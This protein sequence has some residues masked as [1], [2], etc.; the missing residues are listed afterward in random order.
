[1][2]VPPLAN[3]LKIEQSLEESIG[4][5]NQR[6]AD[7]KKRTFRVKAQLSMA[8]ALN[9]LSVTIIASDDIQIILDGL[10]NII[11]ETLQVDHC[12]LYEINLVMNKMEKVSE[13]QRAQT[14]E[15]QIF[16]HGH[17][18]DINPYARDFFDHNQ[19]RIESHSHKMDSDLN[20]S[21]MAEFIHN[22]CKI[23]SF[24]WYPFSFATKGYYSLA[25][26]QKTKREFPQDELE[27]LDSAIKIVE[28][29]IQKI[30]YFTE[31]KKMEDTLKNAEKEKDLILSS[32]SELVILHDKDMRIKWANDSAV[33]YTGVAAK[34]LIGRYC[35]TIWKGMTGF[36][37]DCPIRN[38]LTSGEMS[39]KQVV[40]PSVGTWNIKA[41]PVFD[42]GGE[43]IGAVEVAKDITET[44]QMEMEMARLD[45]M[46]LIGEMA[47]G[48]GHEIRNPMTTV[49]GFL[50]I[51]L[52]KPECQCYQSYFNLMIEEIDRANSI[53]SEFLS[54]AR[55]KVIKVQENDL[56]KIIESMYPL[57]QA[58]AIH[59]D[60]S[61]E[62][63]L[64]DIPHILIDKKE[65][66]QLILNLVRNGLEAMPSGRCV[67]IRTYMDGETVVLAIQDQGI[68]IAP[69][70]VN[71]LG[72]PFVTTKEEGTGLGL[73]ICY[74]IVER[75]N[76][77]IEV[78]S[79]SRGT[80]FYVRYK[81]GL[82]IKG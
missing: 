48:F 18:L 66:Q 44:K 71:K 23:A 3:H 17:P 1:M 63:E 56:N 8:Q 69:E 5:Q 37:S 20:N 75:H 52:E 9:R 73:A 51:L 31:R 43:V 19:Q 68:G 21:G 76:A 28:I 12:M 14:A 46:N 36:C 77:K 58:D 39:K 54:L 67:M 53:I 13:F 10:T 55:Y 47:A 32:I 59:N 64:A 11:G 61:I 25:L 38:A 65:T 6:N 70:V 62:L 24:L 27:F 29:A 35:F 41:F 79:S 34:D 60:Q 22:N 49:R 82:D 45:R 33:E 42:E 40:L 78:E 74:S 2:S 4:F 81:N 16:W 26:A 57:M 80:T 50:Q 7:G 30:K 72:I 15:P